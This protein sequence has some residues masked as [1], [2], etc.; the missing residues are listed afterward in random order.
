MSCLLNARNLP[1]NGL[2]W[3]MGLAR[4]VPAYDLRYD[5][6]AEASAWFRGLLGARSSGAS[7][8]GPDSRLD[9]Q[10]S[11]VNTVI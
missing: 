5:N 11:L 9:Y 10:K 2:P 8:S 1:G 3:V 6:L 7:T 4:Q